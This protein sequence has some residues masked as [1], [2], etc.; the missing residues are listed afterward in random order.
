MTATNESQSVATA[1]AHLRSLGFEVPMLTIVLGSGAKGF[2]DRVEVDHR[3]QFADVPGWPSPK[4]EGHGA[5]LLIGKVSGL[6]IACLTGRV[7][8]YEG[9]TPQEVVR[10]LRTLALLGVSDVLL[11]NASGGIAEGLVPGDLLCITDQINTTG[12]SP[13]LGEWHE[14]FGPRFPDQS[15]VYD[16][17]LSAQLA[18][19]DPDLKQGV[20]VGVLGPS[21]ETPAEIEL[22][23]RAGGA[24]VGM[25]TVHEA[26]AMNAM[27]ARVCGLALI[28]NLAAGRSKE[29]LRHEDV[30]AAGRAAASRME[31]LLVQ[32][33]QRLAEIRD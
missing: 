18:A 28:S 31:G 25:S 10:P 26:T 33:C 13:L 7:H 29:R 3:L 24:A 21:Y 20:Y 5:E 27:G 17:S 8:V 23:A 1:L 16:R 4:V 6:P 14:E 11:T 12:T 15:E 22:F 2:Q 32:F 30:L 9:W 19:C